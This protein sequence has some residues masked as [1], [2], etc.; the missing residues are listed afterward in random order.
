MYTYFC[1]LNDFGIRPTAVW[2][3]AT[4]KGMLPNLTDQYNADAGAPYGNTRVGALL[5]KYDY[6]EEKLDG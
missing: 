4:E 2:K 5:K 6:D 3:L 1:V